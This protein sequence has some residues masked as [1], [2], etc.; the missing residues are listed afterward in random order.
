M[1]RVVPIEE[2]LVLSNQLLEDLVELKGLMHKAAWEPSFTKLNEII[3]KVV[4]EPPI[5]EAKKNDPVVRTET[6]TD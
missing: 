4:G 2:R 5:I 1:K 3:R 6:T